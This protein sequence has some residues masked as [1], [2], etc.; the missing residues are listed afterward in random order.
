MPWALI[1]LVAGIGV[2]AGLIFRHVLLG[3]D[4]DVRQERRVQRL[5]SWYP[6]RWRARYGNEFS[7]LVQD[8]MADGRDG[9]RVTLNVLRESNAARVPV[10]GPSQGVVGWLHH[11]THRVPGVPPH[12][13]GG[14]S[15]R[16]IGNTDAPRHHRRQAR[17]A[18]RRE[19]A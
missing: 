19:G 1:L 2:V 16:T 8:T 13:G 10:E 11:M 4:A 12:P 9:F 7:Q 15:T 14:T 6:A 18:G 17:T 5:L 3:R